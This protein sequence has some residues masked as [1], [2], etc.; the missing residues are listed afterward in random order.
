MDN[1]TKNDLQ[2]T[3]LVNEWRPILGE[4]D[5]VKVLGTGSYGYVVEAINK[6]TKRTVAIKRVTCLFEDL[7][8]TKRILREITL[9][10]FMKNQFVVELLDI[11]Y[12]YKNPDFDTIFLIFECAPSD[13]KKII[14]SNL[15]LSILDVKLLVYHI[16][17]GLKYIHSCAVL[18]RDLKPGNILLDDNYQIKICDFGLARSVYRPDEEEED[19]ENDIKKKQQETQIS[20]EEKQNRRDKL[21]NR[22]SNN[23]DKYTKKSS[24]SGITN[25]GKTTTSGTPFLGKMKNSGK[26]GLSVHVVTRWYRAPELILVE[27]YY[28][29]AIDIWSVGCIFAELL[30]MM[31]ENAKNYSERTPL[32]PGKYCF[33]LSPPDKNNSIKINEF[34]FPVDKTDQL[35]VIFDVIGSPADEDLDF[36][37]DENGI[38]YLKSLKYRNKKSLKTKFPGASDDALDL[39]DKML[40]FNP[41]RRLTVDEA[42]NHDFFE[43]IRNTGKEIEAEFNLNFEYENDD[44]LTMDKLRDLFVNVINSYKTSTD[45]DMQD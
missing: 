44:N 38:L 37:T 30:M 14:K 40:M 18:H 8:D 41:K 43:E 4:Y 1:K 25:N 13:L 20:N 2:N 36:I 34:G 10:R 16:L 15:F 6:K 3:N 19:L 12:E 5:I 29:S 31:K 33:P 39:L 32:F 22:G 42:L 7:I 27:K 21:L 17:C 9:L 26:Q 35:N 24:E 28:T 23:L 45:D 11:A